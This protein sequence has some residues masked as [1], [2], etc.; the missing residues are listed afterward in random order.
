M[1]CGPMPYSCLNSVIFGTASVSPAEDAPMPDAPVPNGVGRP[2]RGYL[3][4]LYSTVQ[5][6][7]VLYGIVRCCVILY[8]VQ[9]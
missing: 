9:L 2:G 8:S 4:V 6:C 7:A 5:Y 3:T 1:G